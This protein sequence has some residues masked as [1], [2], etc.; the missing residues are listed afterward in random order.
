LYETH[1]YYK[2]DVMSIVI[3]DNKD[4]RAKIDTIMT[5][6]RKNPPVKLDNSQV[7]EVRDYSQG[8]ENLP[9]ENVLQFFTE[10]GS[11]VTVRPSG[12]EPKIK[13]YFSVKTKS[14]ADA[15]DKLKNIK[16]EFELIKK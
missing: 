4:G 9:A 8:Y 13:F 1:G 14:N 12:T 15:C 2:E 10:D 3:E 11:K 7:S 6:Y 5:G 16:E